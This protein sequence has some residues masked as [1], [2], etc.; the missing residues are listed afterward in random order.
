M[1]TSM[2]SA[3]EPG[4]PSCS[5]GQQAER[6]RDDKLRLRAA[7][8]I[9]AM[10]ASDMLSARLELAAM[11]GDGEGGSRA[12]AI[13]A[14]VTHAGELADESQCV[15]GGNAIAASWRARGDELMHALLH[16]QEMPQ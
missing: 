9:L 2:Q 1:N 13:L 8:D 4:A 16:G 5:N 3:G 12:A 6:T 7:R 14:L 10:I 11:I 15:M